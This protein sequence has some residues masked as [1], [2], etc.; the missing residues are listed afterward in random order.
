LYSFPSFSRFSASSL[1]N[2]VKTENEKTEIDYLIEEE[3]R[4]I[5]PELDVCPTPGIKAA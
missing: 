3:S 4:K 2:T 5:V 1:T